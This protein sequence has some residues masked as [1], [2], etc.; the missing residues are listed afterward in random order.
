MLR[1]II[2]FE[3]QELVYVKDFALALGSDE[4]DNVKRIIQKYIDLP[5]PGKTIINHISNYQI[6][7]RSSKSVYYVFVTDICDSLQYVES[8][9]LK[10]IKKLEELFPNPHDI[11]EPSSNK[12][13]FL[14]FLVQLQKDLHSK[15]SIIGP[16]NTG[17]TTLY[18]LLKTD[19]EK[20]LTDFAR[21][22]Q[23]KIGG[24]SFD[25]WDFQLRDNF[26]LLWSKFINGSDLVIVLFNLAN[27]HVKI[28]NN[29]LNL[30]KLEGKYSNLL[31]I[32][33]KRELVDDSEIK[34][35]KNI[36]NIGEFEEFSLNAPDA[37]VKITQLL[38]D[39]L[40]LKKKFPSDFGELVK[41]VDALVLENKKI[42]ALAKYK[43][44]LSVSQSYHNIIYTKA[45]EQKISDL[46]EKIKEQTEK[47]RERISKKEFPLPKTL[48][49]TRKI[50]VKPLPLPGSTVQSLENNNA[51]KEPSAST[52]KPIQSMV[53][54]QKL[55][56]KP[57]VKPR[58]IQKKPSKLIVKPKVPKI[59]KEDKTPIKPVSTKK[60]KPTMPIELF[61][62]HEDIVKEI[63]TPKVIDF[64]K[65]LQKRIIEG[66]SSLSMQLCER[67]ITEL[68]NSLD[69]PISLSDVRMAAD[70][71]IKQEQ[72]I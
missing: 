48:V 32:G 72:I 18:N 40:R 54:F 60:L 16:T 29:F 56:S 38:M 63:E 44:L 36:L 11:K 25:L 64:P 22:S 34:R 13:E 65:E 5:V 69:R 15:I 7:H 3:K 24:V 37:K 20:L 21:I 46:N 6:F 49:F 26:S 51:I 62:P 17:K 39:I 58:I 19:N 41:D 45:L 66:G 57:T 43:E 31:V 9:I 14:K 12:S 4:L 50:S 23:F 53:S 2:L 42:Q 1:Q 55:D 67:L 68:K 47:R 61:S 59:F 30:Q 35:I 33:N 28:V 71:F 70:F 10:T 27:Y 52:S 8:L